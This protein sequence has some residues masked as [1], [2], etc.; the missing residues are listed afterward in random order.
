MTGGNT[1]NAGTDAP[2]AATNMT[3]TFTFEQFQQELQK[4]RDAIAGDNKKN[5]DDLNARMNETQAELKEH[6]NATHTE[7]KKSGTT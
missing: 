5:I 6:K 3:M 2:S 4:N 7:L 1:S